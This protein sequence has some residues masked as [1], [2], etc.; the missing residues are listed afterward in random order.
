MYR[1]TKAAH[2]HLIGI[3][4]PTTPPVYDPVELGISRLGV[5]WI[6]HE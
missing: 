5:D 6:L 2:E 3:V 1:P 4:V